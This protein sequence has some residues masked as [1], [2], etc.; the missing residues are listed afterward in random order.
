MICNYGKRNQVLSRRWEGDRYLI[1]PAVGASSDL[2]SV[3]Q[4]VGTAQEV[5]TEFGDIVGGSVIQADDKQGVVDDLQTRA[6]VF[7]AGKVLT[8]V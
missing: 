8:V 2:N 5:G 1:I 7:G 3:G 4:A 6:I